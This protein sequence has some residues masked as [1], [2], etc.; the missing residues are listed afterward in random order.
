MEGMEWLPSQR[1]SYVYSQKYTL[2]QYNVMRRST[3]SIVDFEYIQ[4]KD[5]QSSHYEERDRARVPC[6]APQLPCGA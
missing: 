6:R 2:N 5:I 3:V 1:E 4:L